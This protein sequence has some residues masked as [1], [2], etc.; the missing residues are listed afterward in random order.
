MAALSLHPATS[1]SLF[2]FLKITQDSKISKWAADRLSTAH[3]PNKVSCGYANTQQLCDE[4]S[5]SCMASTTLPVPVPVSCLH[6]IRKKT[7][8]E[9]RAG[10]MVEG[11]RNFF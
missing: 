11:S 10:D 8:V 2:C 9:R 3:H 4:A 5:D 7:W 1:N 6:R